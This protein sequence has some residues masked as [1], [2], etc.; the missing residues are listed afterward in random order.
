MTPIIGGFDDVHEFVIREKVEEVY[1]ALHIDH[2]EIINKLTKICE[3]NLVRIKFIPDFQLYTK[4]SK[5]EVDFYENTPV[6]MLRRE[7]LELAVNRLIKK[8]LIFAFQY[9]L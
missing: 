1:V 7:P 6:L 8:Y 9:L 4:S 5:V 2:I 3:Q